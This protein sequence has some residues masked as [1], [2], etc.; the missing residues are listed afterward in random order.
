MINIELESLKELKH[1][2]ECVEYCLN[3]EKIKPD[4]REIVRKIAEKLRN[5]FEKKKMITIQDMICESINCCESEIEKR[6]LIG[7]YQNLLA[8]IEKELD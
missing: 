6:D 3:N 2:C 1:I 4:E 7:D 8:Q 5:N